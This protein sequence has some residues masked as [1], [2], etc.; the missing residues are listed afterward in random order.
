MPSRLA[1]RRSATALGLYSAAAFGFLATIV[2]AR[3]LGVH[4]FGLFAI[5]MA[6]T[7][8][9]QTLLDLTVEE[10]VTKYGFR[11][12]TTGEWGKLRRLFIRALTFK[13]SGAVLA[14]LALAGLAPLAEH[15]FGAEGLVAP[16]LIAAFLPL[17]QAPEGIAATAPILHGRYDVR[18]YF[19]ALS[20]IL[21]FVAIAIGVQFGLP[22][23]ML[24]I[25]LAQVVATA[26]VGTAGLVYFR[27][28][29]RVPAEP[30]TGES[31]AIRRFVL[32][33]SLATGIV[34]IR[35]SITPLLVGLVSTPAQVAFF[36]TALAPQQGFYT[37]SA[38][39]R[40]VMLTEQTRAWERGEH[41]AVFAG[42]RRYSLFAGMLM[43]AA[44]L[45]LLLF[46]P[47]LI[48]LVFTADY[49]A[50]TDA[51]RIVL[52]AAALQ[53]VFGWTKSFPISIGRPNLRLATHGVETAVLVPL[54]LLLAARWGATGAAVALLVATLV[55]VAYWTVLFLR[56]RAEPWGLPTA[57]EAVAR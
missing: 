2:A 11:Y 18:S 19:V 14:G 37:L 22:E 50:A 43:V 36:R 53:F 31:G 41:G 56:L 54:T 13:G 4:D 7:A 1:W 45:P 40:L 27:R 5:V 3:T 15:L 39:A 47:E 17:A 29:P 16:L 35:A 24:A 9:F 25:V 34:S 6:A 52:V 23:T 42:I 57:R 21:R 44:L 49:L 32:S 30:L 48:E 26:A 46:M 38:P 12:S 33:S 20:M 55:F 8:F 28:F 51:A 10:A